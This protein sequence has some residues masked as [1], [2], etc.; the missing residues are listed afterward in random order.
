MRCYIELILESEYTFSKKK[1]IREG[2]RK[3]LKDVYPVERS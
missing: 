3:W 2:E 1:K